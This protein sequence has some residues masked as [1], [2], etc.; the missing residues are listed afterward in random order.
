[1]FSL[2]KKLEEQRRQRSGQSAPSQSS[3]SSSS[4][5]RPPAPSIRDRLLVR[6]VQE[7][8]ETLPATC[9]LHI[10]RADHLHEL[11]LTVRPAVGAWRGGVFHFNIS[12]GNEYNLEPP[13]VRCST[14]LWHPNIDED[15][16]ICLSLLRMSAFDAHGWTPTRTLKD[17]VWGVDALFDELL[18]FEDPLNVDAAEQYRRDPDGFQRKVCDYIARY[19]S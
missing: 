10:P 13:I 11:V 2:A 7:V 9:C 12:V 8:Q 3:S 4:G 5:V 16:A 1:M 18:N 6:E 15:G 17:V 14:R 19:A